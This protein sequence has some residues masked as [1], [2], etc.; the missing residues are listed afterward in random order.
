MT[1]Q[2]Q[3][4]GANKHAKSQDKTA[5]IRGL[6]DT[7]RTTLIG[8]RIILTEGISSLSPKDID[9]VLQLVSKFD[10]FSEDNDPYG[11]HDFGS[12]KHNGKTVYFKIDYYA[13]GSNLS[14]GSNDPSND[15]L[16]E[17][18]LTIMFSHEY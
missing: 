12:L 11:E 3:T 16:T 18:V 15:K 6:N 2:P 7:F 4:G 17:R 13:A 9:T 1:N 10:T 5:L 8:G 14:W